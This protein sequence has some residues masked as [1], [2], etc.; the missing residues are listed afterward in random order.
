MKDLFSS[1]DSRFSIRTAFLVTSVPALMLLIVMYSV[2]LLLSLN[3][4]YFI[5]NGIPL[6]DREIDIFMDYLM[7]T[8]I[9]YIPFVGLFFISVFFIGL[10]LSHIIL[11]P[12]NE[13]TKMC[14]EIIEA[15]DDRI[16]IVGMER[17]KL[18]IKLGNFISAYF[19]AKKNGR[20][21][22]IPDDLISVQRPVMDYVFHFQFFCLI[23]ILMSIAIGSL[24]VFADQLHAS[25]IQV[26]IDVLKAPKGMSKFLGSQ[27]DAFELI[28]IIPSC[29]GVILYIFLAQF[30]I[31]KIQ[32]VTYGYV[33]DICE[34]AR[35]NTQRRLSPR[36]DDPGLQSAVKLNEVLD[37][38]H[39][40]QVAIKQV[41]SEGTLIST[42]LTV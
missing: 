32:G 38:L 20:N 34:V 12:F 13:L 3:F 10:F 7:Q 33:R 30:I 5:S 23:F 25:I 36:K 28:V 26:A 2:W 42:K 31:S 24:Y 17:S 21:V 40:R 39:P 35:G 16:K 15:K 37:L 8:Q 29:V 18:L 27:K 6:D 41:Q 14:E 19:H 1:Y 11:R 9:D 22:S 4:S